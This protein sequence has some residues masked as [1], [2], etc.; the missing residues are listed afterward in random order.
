MVKKISILF[1]CMGN[2][3]RSPTAEG[4]MRHLAREHGLDAQCEMDSAGTIDFHAGEPPDRRAIAHAR[5]RGYDLSVLRARQIGPPDFESF[6]YVLAMDK[7]NL[8]WLEKHCP[9]EHQHK[10][11]L[12]LAFSEKFKNR[13][14]P[15]P[16][17]GNAKGFET[18]LDMAEDGAHGLITHL[19]KHELNHLKLS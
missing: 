19:I 10:L 9:A 2:I 12:F 14:M 11:T 3:C 8:L 1:V 6:D 18:V 13:D 4:V 15:D 16:Y 7:Q 17:Y 5:A